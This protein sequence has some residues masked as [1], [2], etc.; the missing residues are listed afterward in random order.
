MGREDA[1]WGAVEPCV[2]PTEVELGDA[3]GWVDASA[4]LAGPGLAAS[5]AQ[6]A[7]APIKSAE[8]RTI[9][10]AVARAIVSKRMFHPRD[11]QIEPPG[12]LI[13]KGGHRSPKHASVSLQHF[14]SFQR[15]IRSSVR[16]SSPA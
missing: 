2:A 12:I 10:E 6:A 16:Q 11:E 15:I 9:G 4:P 3:A 1:V 7:E 5:W 13:L 8:A 14:A